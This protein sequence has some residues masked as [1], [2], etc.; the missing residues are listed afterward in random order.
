MRTTPDYNKTNK[1][2]HIARPPNAWILYRADKYKELVRD[3]KTLHQP[4]AT[5]AEMS[6]KLS[7]L[8]RHESLEVKQFYEQRADM[9]KMEHL[10]LYPDYRFQPK[11]KELKE[12]LK[13]EQKRERAA[14]RALKASKGKGRRAA[15]SSVPPPSLPPTAAQ[16]QV[17][18]P[19]AHYGPQGPSPPLSAA[20]SP[21]LLSSDCDDLP[22]TPSNTS[23]NHYIPPLPLDPS[24]KLESFMPRY[25]S[26]S[27]PS[28]HALSSQ[29]IPGPSTTSSSVAHE[30]EQWFDSQNSYVPLHA[31]IPSWPAHIPPQAPQMSQPSSTSPP[32]FINYSVPLPGGNGD[33]DAQGFPQDDNLDELLK[34]IYTSAGPPG[35]FHIDV[36]DHD[37][38]DKPTGQL[39]L[40][41]LHEQDFF[42][43]SR[44]GFG[45]PDF[46][47]PGM[48]PATSTAA[49]FPAD[50]QPYFAGASTDAENYDY[51]N[52]QFNDFLNFDSGNDVPTPQAESRCDQPTPVQSTPQP[53]STSTLYAPPPGAMHSSSRRVA[54][55]WKAPP[56]APSDSSP[57]DTTTPA[58]WVVPAN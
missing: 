25:P 2:A 40:A 50:I 32:D 12:R 18:Y 57:V 11:S 1:G 7:N 33:F 20:S 44:L 13:V 35:V 51:N 41:P 24:L 45:D 6:K 23:P 46:G 15:S 43:L 10:A 37:L 34:A 54:G 27:A 42:N 39:E 55:S 28:P 52:F 48:P 47:L 22:I 16:P 26:Q 53:S 8:W 49:D 30:T 58:G 5:Q 38:L 14:A 3:R 36:N 17:F 4:P 29:Q 31:P 56:F 21:T 9:R 19:Q